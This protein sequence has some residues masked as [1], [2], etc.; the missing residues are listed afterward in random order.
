MTSVHKPCN[1]RICFS[2]NTRHPVQ[3]FLEF[4]N[5]SN[6]NNTYI[7]RQASKYSHSWENRSLEIRIQ[8]LQNWLK[9]GES[10]L[11]FWFS[12]CLGPEK[13]IASIRTVSWKLLN[14]CWLYSLGF[15]EQSL[16]PPFKKRRLV[17]V[18]EG[19]QSIFNIMINW[20]QKH[21]YYFSI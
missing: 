5:Y 16:S 20:K 7:I 15:T 12:T 18:R 9:P 13:Y 10:S 8:L 21:C 14:S 4:S 1:S 6:N 19:Y 17:K 11:Q 2:M 3:C